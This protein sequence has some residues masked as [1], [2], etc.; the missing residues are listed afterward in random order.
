MEEMEKQMNDL[1][2]IR[3]QL[4]K[5]KTERNIARR[6]EWR[7]KGLT[8]KQKRGAAAFSQRNPSTG[9]PEAGEKLDSSPLQIELTKDGTVNIKQPEEIKE[10]EKDN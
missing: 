6:L 8:G 7:R 9:R 10:K 2:F 4:S 5:I 3:E 1:E